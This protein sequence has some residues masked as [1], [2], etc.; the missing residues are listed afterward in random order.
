MERRG[1]LDLMLAQARRF[2]HV[3]NTETN[4]ML[5][6]KRTTG[7]NRLGRDAT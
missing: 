1:R 6:P 3:S 5:T 4:L 7:R 2:D